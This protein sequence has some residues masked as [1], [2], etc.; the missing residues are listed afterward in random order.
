MFLSSLRKLFHSVSVE[1]GKTDEVRVAAATTLRV[2]Q[3]ICYITTSASGA[4]AITL[5]NSAE[6]KGLFYF[7][8]LVLKSTNDCT[9]S[10]NGATVATL[11]TTGD[12]VL[13]VSTGAEWVPI[14]GTYT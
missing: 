11:D 6:A 13:V 14:G 8:K 3:Q 2:S 5:P 10:G 12:N 4:F 1:P 7:V 9:V